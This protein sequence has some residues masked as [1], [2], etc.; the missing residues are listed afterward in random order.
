MRSS[1]EVGSRE[2]RGGAHDVLPEADLAGAFKG[3]PV[4]LGHVLDVAAPVQELVHLDVRVG[5]AVAD[6]VA[7]VALGEEAGGSKDQARQAVVPVG[8]LAEVL[9]RRLRDAVD[10]ARDGRDVLVDPGGGLARARGERA[11]ERARGAREDEAPHA[12]GHRLL[13]QVERAGDVRVDEVLPTVRADVRLVERGG[14]EDGLHAGHA[15][16][17]ECAVGDR[18]DRARVRG[19]EHVEPDDV[20]ALGAEHADQR[21]AEVAGAACD[22]DPHGPRHSSRGD[23]AAFTGA[24]VRLW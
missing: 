14:M 5:I 9:R 10:V 2:R 15:A 17:H 20:D 7:V 3:E 23:Q 22:Q 24:T 19:I 16:A 13:E 8:E 1:G 21:L 4:R 12:R 11:P 6:L 18:A